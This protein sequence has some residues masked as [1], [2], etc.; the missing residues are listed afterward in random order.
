MQTLPPPIQHYLGQ[1]KY[2]VV[3]RSLA[4]KYGL[5]VDQA[6]VLELEIMLLL[7]GI[8]NPDEFTQ[9]LV[10]EAKLDQQTVNGITRDVNEQIFIP[11][12]EQMKS[13]GGQA[14]QPVR[15][16]APATPQPRA[17]APVP[18]YAPAR[19][20]TFTP[21]PQPAWRASQM[22]PQS[23][24][25][26]AN[27]SMPM[28]P[29]QQEYITKVPPKYVPPRPSAPRPPM[30]VMPPRPAAPI[31]RPPDTGRMLEDHEE[32]H[33]EFMPRQ[34]VSQ[35]TPPPRPVSPEPPPPVPLT[36]RPPMEPYSSD[37]Y[38]EP[39]DEQTAE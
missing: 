1:G 10:E 19:P 31:Q 29:Q 35:I 6:N 14:E 4:I 9:A 33:I 25:I 20:P 23:V 34:S 15:P 24:I 30:N 28:R 16:V 13:G 36:P 17:S 22:P 39:F 38:R 32:P 7:M 3:A 18:N 2:S 12:R 21:P 37:P 11:L 27:P 5:R 26:P 8:D